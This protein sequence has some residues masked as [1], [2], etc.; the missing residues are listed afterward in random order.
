MAENR[1]VTMK[2][3]DVFG[4]IVEATKGVAPQTR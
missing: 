4:W 3:T 1:K 2:D